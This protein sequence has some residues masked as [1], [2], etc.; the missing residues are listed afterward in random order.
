MLAGKTG[1]ALLPQQVQ[2]LFTG[3]VGMAVPARAP[4]KSVDQALAMIEYIAS[5]R[6]QVTVTGLSRHFGWSKATVHRLL[7]TLRARGYV[8]RDPLNAHYSF[9]L[10]AT[11]LTQQ[12]QVGD[13]L[14]HACWPAMKWLSNSSQETVLLAVREGDR[15]VFSTQRLGRLLPVHTVSTGMA[16]LASLPDAEIRELLPPQLERFTAH[17]PTTPERVCSAVRAAR[18]KGYAINREQYRP[19]VSGV[20]ALIWGADRRRPIAAISVCVP[21]PRFEQHVDSLCDSVLAAAAQASA[22]FQGGTALP[23]HYH[24]DL[25]K[26]NGHDRIHGVATGEAG[27]TIEGH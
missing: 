6:G 18:T 13:C 1:Y 7:S 15:A 12:A 5:T 27:S 21:S 26:E 23:T 8:T 4:L 19:G 20:A 25:G 3:Q 9:G 10:M 17:T 22:E 11:Q 14:T 24:R 16:L 2:P